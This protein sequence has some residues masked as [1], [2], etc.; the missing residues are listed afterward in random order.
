[1]RGKWLEA[2]VMEEF[3]LRV[4]APL[5]NGI[6]SLRDLNSF[7]SHCAAIIIAG[8]LSSCITTTTGGFNVDSSDEAAIDDYMRLAIAYYDNGDMVGAR[9]HID[10]ALRIDDDNSD[11]YT[12]LAQIFQSEGDIGLAEDNFRRA[13]RLDRENSRARNNYAALL[14]SLQRYE[15]A[16]EQLQLVTQDTAYEGRSIAFENL[17]RSAQ[18]LDMEQEAI[19]AFERALQL[20]SNLYVSALELALINFNS[21]DWDAARQNFQHYLTIVEIY[22]I[23]HTP[24]ALLA[25]IQIEGHFQ[26]QNMVDGFSIIL[27]TLYQDTP[28]FQDYQRLS[29]A[30]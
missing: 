22:N 16:V 2:K 3:K 26:N 1:M 6:R 18:R 5:I 10:N 4:Q 14:F 19:V 17:G 9:R 23:Q 24:R 15:D 8:L 21:Q 7:M 25:G 27:S 20:N 30:N 13:I 11:I 29:D 12:V 28:E